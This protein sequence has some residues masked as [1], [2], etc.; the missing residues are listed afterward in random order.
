M[1]RYR[2]YGSLNQLRTWHEVFV[3]PAEGQHFEYLNCAPRTGLL[4]YF[5]GERLA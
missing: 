2:K 3:L 1:A 4:P 5:D